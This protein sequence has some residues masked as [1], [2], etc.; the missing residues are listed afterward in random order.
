MDEAYV[1]D[2]EL[3]AKVVEVRR[4]VEEWCLENKLTMS[5]AQLQQCT[6]CCPRPFIHS[7][8]LNYSSCLLSTLKMQSE[9]IQPIGG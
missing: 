5:C 8:L 4:A 3:A 7:L 2:S 9:Y 1:D 6:L